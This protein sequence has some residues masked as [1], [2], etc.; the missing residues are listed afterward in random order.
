[1]LRHHI[2]RHCADRSRVGKYAGYRGYSRSLGRY[3]VDL[4]VLRS[5]SSL[6]VAVEGTKRDAVAV[7]RLSHT[8]AGSACALKYSCTR[9]NK[10]G[11][12]T[13]LCHHVVNLLGAGSYRKA[14]IGVYCL[15][16]EDMRNFEKIL[17]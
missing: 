9:V 10:I 16:L 13:A 14:H 2:R 6:E 11:E 17:H 3:E 12:R 1:M 5:A 7:R 15:A 4:T 8:D